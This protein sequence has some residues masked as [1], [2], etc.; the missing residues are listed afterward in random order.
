M[1]ISLSG[2]RYGPLFIDKLDI[3]TGKIAITGKNGAGKTLLLSLISGILTPEEGEIDIGGKN[4]R[5]VSIGWVSAFPDQN[6]LFSRTRDEI[7]SHLRFAHYP[8][9]LIDNVVNETA[10]ILKIGHLLE[11]P[12]RVLSG[13]EK[14]MV[15]V[16]AALVGKPDI[17][18]FDE[19][20]AYLDTET[21]W[22]VDSL[23]MHQNLS[24]LIYTSHRA[25]HI[26]MADTVIVMNDGRVTKGPSCPN[27][28]YLS[29]LSS[30]KLWMRIHEAYETYPK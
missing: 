6:M 13:G 20:D 24:F 3:P 29:I 4:P 17:L 28:I 19:T 12:V 11:R 25:E 9:E 7:S 18:I 22:H 23:S 27:E 15:A 16:A 26:A 1:K 14:I 8:P 5:E 10:E 21:I 2:V 30:P